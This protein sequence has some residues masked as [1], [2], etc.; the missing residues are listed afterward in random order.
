MTAQHIIN[1]IEFS[2]K[3]LKIHDTIALSFF[4]KTLD[5]L[6]TQQGDLNWSLEG[7]VAGQH[8]KPQ[9]VLT[10]NGSMQL[11]CQKCLNPLMHNLQ[12]KQVYEL[13]KD[14]SEIP[15]DDD[16][17]QEYLEIS[18]AFDVL[19]LIENELILA[20]PY[21]PKH[22]GGCEVDGSL[23]SGEPQGVFAALKSLKFDR[24]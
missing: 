7:L 21:A 8:S 18:E 12:I 17:E 24:R 16:S 6:A 13:V 2:R 22:A 9:L 11:M 10:I 23:S 4:S 1:T 5:L 19:Q 15:V 20:M 14:E 3:S